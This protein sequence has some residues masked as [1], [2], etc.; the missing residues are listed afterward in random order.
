M[1]DGGLQ[2][3]GVLVF[4]DEHMIETRAEFAR[5]CGLGEHLRPGGEQVV[6]IER[7]LM[8]FFARIG[9]EQTLEFSFPLRAPRKIVAQHV[10]ERHL[11]V[12]HAR[13]DRE[14]GGLEWK[15]LALRGQALVLPHQA[16]EVFGIAAVEDGEGIGQTDARRVFAQQARADAMEG[17]GPA[18]LRHALRG[19]EPE[20]LM[21]HPAH[22]LFHGLRGATRKR[23]Q[24]HALR[25]GAREHQ[26]RDARGQRHGLARAGARNDEQRRRRHDAS[27]RIEPMLDRGALRVVQI[28]ERIGAIE[29]HIGGDIGSGHVAILLDIHPANTFRTSWTRC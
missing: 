18:Q 14:T 21:Q 9:A 23:E 17:A 3:V 2:A 26:T 10:G 1:Q 5:E 11:L 8:Q 12:D 28:G 25:I 16:H 20:R 13:I 27:G 29:D 19:R 6:V 22:T 7:V 24:Q 15:P 4:I